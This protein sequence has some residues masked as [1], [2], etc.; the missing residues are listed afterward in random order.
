MEQFYDLPRSLSGISGLVGFIGMLDITM[1]S[2]LVV[3][4]M[5]WGS[6]PY[7]DWFLVCLNFI[8]VFSW[9]A[10]LILSMPVYDA[11]YGL[12]VLLIEFVLSLFIFPLPHNRILIQLFFA[13]VDGVYCWIRFRFCDTDSKAYRI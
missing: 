4:L 7:Y 11:P 6:I 8:H 12:M 2:S 3:V 9:F 1:T 10:A 13:G 5:I